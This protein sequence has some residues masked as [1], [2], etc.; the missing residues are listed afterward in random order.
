MKNAKIVPAVLILCMLLLLPVLQSSTGQNSSQAH[1]NQKRVYGHY[2]PDELPTGTGCFQ[3]SSSNGNVVQIP[4][5][6][7]RTQINRTGSGIGNYTGYNNP[8]TVT[9]NSNITETAKFTY[10]NYCPLIVV[11]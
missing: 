7:D 10:F 5:A 4:C 1:P 9:M 3:E 2:L 6:T 8:A 11:G